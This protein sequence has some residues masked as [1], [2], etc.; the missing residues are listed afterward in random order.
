[1]ERRLVESEEMLRTLVDNQSEG[2]SIIDP[3][4]KFIF[5]NPAMDTILGLERANLL[6]KNIRDFTDEA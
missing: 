3:E 4:G 2:V 5:C 1:M 6:G